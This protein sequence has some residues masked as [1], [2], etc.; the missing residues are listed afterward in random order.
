MPKTLEYYTA[1]A[2]RFF[3]DTVA[4]DMSALHVRF[5]ATIPAGGLILDAG[6]GSGRDA[7]AFK[8]RGYRVHAFD[9]SPNLAR[10]ASEWVGQHVQVCQFHDFDER[11]RYDGIWACASL[12]HVREGSM[13]DVLARLWAALKPEGVLY[14]SFKL[15]EGQRHYAGR[16]F[17]DATEAQLR[18]WL[19]PIPAIQSITCWTTDDQRTDRPEIWLNALV[20]RAP[21][22]A[23]KL[24]TGEASSPFL[25]QLSAA[26]AQADEV[27]LAVA[28]VKATGLRLLLDDLQTA[29]GLGEVRARPPARLRVL[30]SDYLDV[31]D[32]EALRHLLLLQDQG[33]QIRVF[34]AAGA[35]FHM[36]AY[37]FAQLAQ[38]GTLRGTAFIGSS[39]ISRMALTDGLEWNYRIDFPGD[40]GFVEARARFEMIF[41]D[42]RTVSLTDA[43]IEDYEARRVPP[44]RTIAPGSDERDPP[45]V[46]TSVQI[47]ALAALAA[48]R[49]DSYRRGLVVL[50]TGLG[51]TWL[52]AF[53]AR[54]M[55]ARRVLFIAHREEILNQAAETFMRIRPGMRVGL[56][57]G[58]VRD[59]TADVLCA[60]VQT[61]GRAAHLD[62]FS[63]QHFDYIVIDEFH[64][65]A[66]PT[67]RRVLNHFAPQFLLGL[68]ATPDRTDQSDILSLCDDNLV[69]DCTL[70]AGI[71][72]G[73]LAPFHYFGIWDENVD[74]QQI[75]W[76]S[77]HFDPE[78][79]TNKLATLARARHALRQWRDRAQARTLAFCVSIRH[80]EYMAD[81]FQRDGVMAEAVYAGSPLGRTD[82]LD[83]LADGRLQVIFSV[84]LFN[85]G[86]DLPAIDTVLMLRPT[87][88]KILF[89]QQLGR[90]L[91]KAPGKE[92][93]VVLDF[94]GNHN[95]FLHK[96]QALANIGSSYRQLA[97]FA[98]AVAA[99][100]LDLP[101]GCFINYDLALIDFLKALDSDGI[102][103]EYLALREGLGHRP[104]LS[105][106]YRAGIQLSRM[107]R[108]HG[109]WFDLVATMGDLTDDEAAAISAHAA[110]LKTV[111]TTQITKSFKM[112]LLEALQ[113]LDGWT[114]PPSVSALAGRSW[115]VLQRRRPFLQDLPDAL[116][117]IKDGTDDV[118]VRYWGAN[119]INAWT[120]GNRT[121]AASSFFRIR[122][123][124]FEPVFPVLPAH[125]DAFATLT[126]ELIDYRL[127]AYEVRQT[128]AAPSAEIIPFTRSVPAR[129]ELAYFPNLPIACGHFKTG[130][131]DAEEHIAIGEGYGRLDPARH[132]IARA[133]GNSMN[134]GKNPICD[135]DYLLLELIN[136]SNAGAITGS[137]MA[138][139]RQD[140]AGDNQYLLR[141]VTKTSDGRYVLKANNPDYA[142]LEANEHMRTFARL[143]G[144]VDPLN[145]AVG[146]SFM[147]E[148][149]PGLFGETFNTGSWHAGHIVLRD[150][151]IHI[152]LVTLNKQ[153]KGIDHRYLDHWI[154]E[155]S[156]HW[157]SQKATIPTISKG[158]EIINHGKLGISIHLFVR[159][160][161]LEQ[162]KAAPFV[163]EGQVRYRGHTGSAP[164]SVVFDVE[165]GASRIS[166]R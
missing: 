146:R 34:E 134:G 66:A 40:D 99:Q 57:K 15:G 165:G 76:R 113:E 71:T 37:L 65:A 79:L 17:T 77:G 86:V 72:A 81:Q 141:M 36:K 63:P 130:Y 107:R 97:Q 106:F 156:F 148:D 23:D 60:S 111:E 29:L 120:G 68:T 30:T 18:A 93:L 5:L 85:E 121:D 89:L 13:V 61:L 150:K 49:N 123:G 10:M 2:A 31:T 78:Q 125:L 21:I 54:A 32:P 12:L 33:A 62:R 98:M 126:Q 6:C 144:V 1:N 119:P 45:P 112:I 122:D 142:E 94:I 155:H 42:H 159:G 53:D 103:K 82:A 101:P 83:R 74:Y 157:Q 135:G 152:L 162:G 90:G 25:P 140:E 161:K 64:H 127:A 104:S 39:N 116:A 84:D 27:D 59:H 38:D 100:R 118:W 11:D 147:R 145:L 75:P 88:S 48:T 7:K 137:V 95:S 149:I 51:K 164:M 105:E 136:S 138:I 70:F 109:G 16:N 80:A 19:E 14:L 133:S 139:E 28:F 50:A 20:R 87:E 163:Y 158:N 108:D 35:S 124:Y 22:A 3:A 8:D 92:K 4:V 110:F 153:G 47:E 24:I 160:H 143:R 166:L 41:R 9:A 151:K 154:D 117:D 129:L 115:Q 96:P 44:S 73:L 52:A 114:Q 128:A 69:F 91:R 26:M 55:G 67:Y 131:A 132:F 58:Q 56:Y 43:W 46:P 102:D